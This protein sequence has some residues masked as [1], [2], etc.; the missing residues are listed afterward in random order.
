[1]QIQRTG[2]RIKGFYRWA[3]YALRWGM[4]HETA[5]HRLKVLT[6]FE[7]HGLHATQDAFQVS[8]RTLYRWKAAYRLAAGNP[9]ALTPRSAAPHRRRQRHWPGAS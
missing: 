5:Q 8:R 9:A 2:Y 1:M 4:L 6:F 7:T 3:S